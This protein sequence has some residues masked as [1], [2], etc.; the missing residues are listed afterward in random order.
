M[1]CDYYLIT[2]LIVEYKTDTDN[3][4]KTIEI[5]REPKYVFSYDSDDYTFDE[6]IEY[7]IKHSEETN[8]IYDSGEWKIKNKEKQEYYKQIIHEE[9]ILWNNINKLTKHIY[10]QIRY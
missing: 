4:I 3:E 5:L 7:Q 1:G 9:N 8:T 2:N 10:G 6:F